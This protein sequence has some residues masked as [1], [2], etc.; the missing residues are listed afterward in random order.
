MI[1]IPNSNA[2]TDFVIP[3]DLMGEMALSLSNPNSYV[4][5]R[6]AVERFNK[7]N[8]SNIDP[9]LIAEVLVKKGYS[10]VSIPERKVEI[11]PTPEGLVL[12]AKQVERILDEDRLGE[13]SVLNKA[14]EIVQ[15]A[16]NGRGPLRDVIECIGRALVRECFSSGP[17]GDKDPRVVGE[18][19]LL[20]QVKFNLRHNTAPDEEHESL[21]AR[22]VEQAKFLFEN[23]ESVDQL[24]T[25][26]EQ[27]QRTR[28]HEVA[29]EKDRQTRENRREQLLASPEAAERWLFGVAR[30]TYRDAKGSVENAAQDLMK[31]KRAEELLAHH[32]I[33]LF[34]FVDW[35]LAAFRNEYDRRREMWRIEAPLAVLLTAFAKPRTIDGSPQTIRK[36]PGEY[37]YNV[38]SQ[39]FGAKF[40]KELP[41][42]AYVDVLCSER[43]YQEK[44]RNRT[45]DTM[46]K[47]SLFGYGRVSDSFLEEM[48]R[49]KEERNESEMRG[50]ES[51]RVAMLWW[52]CPLWLQQ[53][54]LRPYIGEELWKVGTCVRDF[55]GRQFLAHIDDLIAR[56]NHLIRLQNTLL[57]TFKTGDQSALLQYWQEIMETGVPSAST[58]LAA[59]TAAQDTPTQERAE[60]IVKEG[61]KR[62]RKLQEMRDMVNLE[63]VMSRADRETEIGRRQQERARWS[64]S[65]FRW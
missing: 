61:R 20:R 26:T 60:A 8:K 15:H 48:D 32:S 13:F 42:G 5:V 45:S 57:G 54:I 62:I 30:G 27:L 23:I 18:G 1:D 19:F 46:R 64:A 50:Y 36:D 11:Q 40:V 31:N 14:I 28:H 55:S 51:S 44:C 6:S 53:K 56:Q 25:K 3:A 10:I 37:V 22:I 49:E 34:D 47:D 16:S 63:F 4:L 24:L 43:E 65:R 41:D 7:T 39:W 38:V 12:D 21:A 59:H 29:A 33:D 9:I 35:Q 52:K 58:R 2:S 17:E